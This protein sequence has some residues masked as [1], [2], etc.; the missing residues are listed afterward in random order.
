MLNVTYTS[1][2][3]SLLL[4]LAF[5]FTINLLIFRINFFLFNIYSFIRKS[6]RRYLQWIIL[7]SITYICFV[8]AKEHLQRPFR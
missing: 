5:V 1:K 6:E 4:F 2:L 8:P 3:Q 7:A